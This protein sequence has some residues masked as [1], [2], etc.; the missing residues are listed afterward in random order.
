MTKQKWAPNVWWTTTCND[1]A[2]GSTDT[3]AHQPF[4]TGP[5]SFSA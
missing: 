2:V 3:G 4:G 1:D 5:H